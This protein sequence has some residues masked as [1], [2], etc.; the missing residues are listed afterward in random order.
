MTDTTDGTDDDDADPADRHQHNDN[1][2]N[3]HAF[4]RSQRFSPTPEPPTLRNIRL[5]IGP[6]MRVPSRKLVARSQA[7]HESELSYSEIKSEANL[8]MNEHILH[9]PYIYMPCFACHILHAPLL[10]FKLKR[11]EGLPSAETGCYLGN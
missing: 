2:H 9:D 8:C 4:P 3:M 7:M 11:T 1:D 6:G 10:F 5:I